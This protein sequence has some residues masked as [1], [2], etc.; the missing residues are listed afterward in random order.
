MMLP[1]RLDSN[2]TLK[3]RRTTTS[4]LSV[5]SSRRTTVP[6][7]SRDVL[8]QQQDSES[9]AWPNTRARVLTFALAEEEDV[10]D[11]NPETN[12]DARPRIRVVPSHPSLLSRR[13]SVGEKEGKDRKEEV[14]THNV[15]VETANLRGGELRDL[16]GGVWLALFDGDGTCAVNHVLGLDF[17]RGTQETFLVY[18]SGLGDVSKVWIGPGSST[19][20]LPE[21]VTVESLETKH[22]AV[23]RNN[24]MLGERQG[25]SAAELKVFDQEAFER[26]VLE[27]NA[28]YAK[29]RNSLLATDAFL[30]S[31]G[32]GILYFLK[33]DPEAALTFGAGGA[34]DF[35]YLSLLSSSVAAIGTP[36]D[37]QPL[38][39]KVFSFP[40][41]RFLLVLCSTYLIIQNNASNTSADA[42]AGAQGSGGA[43]QVLPTILETVAGL[44]MYKVAVLL[45]STLNAATGAGG[46]T[47]RAED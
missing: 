42:L 36:E 3:Q 32:G 29:L 45:V 34:I 39:Q 8:K 13:L 19:T 31:L 14:A 37:S 23:F 25:T 18:A 6:S 47:E 15:I 33:E 10:A 46:E 35:L 28:N 26:N 9:K 16:S 30:V 24:A 17:D 20:W 4:T 7:R 12:A 2:K 1:M 40:A 27:D 44:L 21:R 43:Q 38:L 11:T 22:V 5:S 41:T